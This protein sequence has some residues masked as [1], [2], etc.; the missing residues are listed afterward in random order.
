MA[1]GGILDVGLDAG[2]SGHV[3]TFAI[4]FGGFLYLIV[5]IL[6]FTHAISWAGRQKREVTAPIAVWLAVFALAW[7]VTIPALRYLP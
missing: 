1:R 2:V 5:T 6:F 4:I 7:P 3:L